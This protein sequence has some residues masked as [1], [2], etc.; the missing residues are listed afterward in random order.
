MATN[1][2]VN[3][4]NHIP[5]AMDYREHE[6]TFSRFVTLIKWTVGVAAVLMVVLYFLVQP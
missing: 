4:P 2:P 1:T 5:S 3:D 6:R